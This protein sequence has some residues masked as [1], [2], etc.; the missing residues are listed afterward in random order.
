L[1][2]FDGPQSNMRTVTA[3]AASR[4]PTSYWD[5]T[6]RANPRKGKLITRRKDRRR[7][8]VTG[9]RRDGFRKRTKPPLAKP[10]ADA[11]GRPAKP[12]AEGPD[13]LMD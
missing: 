4:A 3:L 5:I 8:A 12:A 1:L 2:A 13:Q 10:S 11:I 9:L 6:G 7:K